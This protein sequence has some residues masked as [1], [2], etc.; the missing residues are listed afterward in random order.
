LRRKAPEAFILVMFA[1]NADNMDAWEDDRASAHTDFVK[2]SL[3]ETVEKALA[4]AMRPAHEGSPGL[5]Q[6][7]I[8]HRDA[9]LSRFRPRTLQA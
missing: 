6:R 4:V 2:Q 1:G 7:A 3:C 9:W 8:S 5:W